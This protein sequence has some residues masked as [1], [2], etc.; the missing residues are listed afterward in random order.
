MLDTDEMAK[1]IGEFE[2]KHSKIQKFLLSYMN[3]FETI[4]L[5][6]RATRARDLQLLMES[7]Q[8][9]MKYFFAHDHLNYARLFPL[10][11]STMQEAEKQNPSS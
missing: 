10:N 1:N 2:A 6:I 3:Q 4:L 8:S 7:I 5:F 9:L 11:I